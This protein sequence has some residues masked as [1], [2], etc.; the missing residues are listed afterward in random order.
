[1][2][3]D[4]TA[5]VTF[6]VTGLE[7]VSGA[8]RLVALAAVEIDL[9]GVVVVVQGVQVIRQRGRISTQAPRF[10]NPRTGVWAPAVILPEELGLAIAKE[11]H[12]ALLQRPGGIR[13]P[14]LLAP[15]EARVD[16]SLAAE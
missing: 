15:L 16:D 1:V 14:D 9:E 13:L 12:R 10:R 7:R 5:T 6:V 8:G 3:S 4:S 2:S 11:L